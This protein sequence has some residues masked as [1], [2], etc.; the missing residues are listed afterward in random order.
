SSLSDLL[1]VPPF[2]TRRSSDLQ[3]AI[4]M[5]LIVGATLFVGTLIKLYAVDRGFDSNG[6]LI[7][8][9]RSSRPYSDERGKAVK[10]ALIERLRAR[11]EEHTSELQSPDH[12]VCRLL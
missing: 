10:L 2:P 7:V 6:V 3:L 12:I 1:D 8:T 11:S 9:L 4:S 5:I